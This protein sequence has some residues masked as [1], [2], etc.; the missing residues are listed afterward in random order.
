M[1]G[2]TGGALR[3]VPAR[4]SSRR[5][6]AKRTP[7]G[8]PDLEARARELL[9]MA[10]HDLRS[11]LVSIGFRSHDVVQRLHRFFDRRVLIE[12]VDL[13]EID[14]VGP[15]SPERCVDGVHDVPARE[16]PI[17]GIITH[18]EEHLSS[19]DHFVPFGEISHSSAEDFLAHSARV[20]IRR[21]EKVDPQ[22]ECMFDERSA[23][24]L[25]E[26]PR[27]PAFRA[28]RHH[29]EAKSRDS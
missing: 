15:K 17:A 6:G 14:I 2:A 29:A 12:A 11:P 26:H 13:V 22:L 27:S 19:Y 28:V 8:A 20:H 4:F 9:T 24:L 16:S 21:V 10:A 1:I 18:R 25:C 3:K 7:R 5:I 23:F